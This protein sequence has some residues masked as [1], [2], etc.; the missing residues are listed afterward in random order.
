MDRQ[1]RT[2]R[3]RLGL[4]ALL[5]VPTVLPAQSQGA[6]GTANA[7]LPSAPAPQ[8]GGST[9]GGFPVQL[10]A[11]NS[12]ANAYL[13]SVQAYPAVPHQMRLALDDVFRMGIANNLGLVYARQNEDL[14][15]AQHKQVLNVLLPNIDV[16][17]GTGLHQFNLRAEG[18]SPGLIQQFSAILPLG[19]GAATTSFPSIVKVDVTQGQA[20]FSQYLFNWYGY[21]L[22]KALDHQIKSAQKA[23]SSSRGQVVQNAGIAYLRVVAAKAQVGYDQSLL[24]TDAGVLYQSEQRHVAGVG[25]RL[26][27][28][29]S[30][31]QYQTQQQA[32]I[33]DQTT[34]AKAKIALNRAIGLAPE[35]DIDVTDEE[36]FPSL[37]EMSPQEAIRQALAARQDYQADLEQMESAR[38]EVKAA[39]RERFPTLRFDGDYGVLGTSGGSYHG[40]FT[41]IGTLNIPIF[42][43]AKFRS[44]HQQA[45]FTLEQARAQANNLRQ[46]ISQQ[47]QDDLINLRAAAVTVGVARSNLE[48]SQVALTQAI[49]R[50]HAGIEDNLP[51]TQSQSTLSE[52][53]VQFVNATFQRNESRLNLARDLG[54]IDLDFHPEWQGGHPAALRTMRASLG[55]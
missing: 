7:P 5:A 6:S 23:S 52:A 15:Q 9:G 35:Q 34:L 50:Y 54:M 48:L 39:T 27:E 12:L 1:K 8:E 42:E 41:A 45:Q 55:N 14:Y 30:R 37:A 43:E 49:D 11:Q 22:V 44:D 21:D 10:P 38:L 20:N 40:V 51:S 3:W 26:D 46:Q 47:V 29:R 32:L 36:P 25:T 16:T 13:G 17:G 53:Q 31:V 24:S 19:G 18:F 2:G 28:T 33:Q 4:V